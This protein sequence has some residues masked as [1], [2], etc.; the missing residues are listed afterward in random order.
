[1]AA[2]TNAITLLLRGHTLEELEGL[3]ASGKLFP[4]SGK[5]DLK[6][7]KELEERQLGRALQLHN[8]IPDPEK[9][10]LPDKKGEKQ[11]AEERIE[12]RME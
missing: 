9:A 11:N 2:D 3:F 1:M 5:K 7:L 8:G 4:R 10:A 12:E 6:T